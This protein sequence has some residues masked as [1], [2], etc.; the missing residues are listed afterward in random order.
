MNGKK[1]RVCIRLLAMVG[2]IVMLSSACASAAW[3]ESVDDAALKIPA[4]YG[5]AEW[6]PFG[7]DTVK[8]EAVPGAENLVKAE[9]LSTDG[10][11]RLYINGEKVT[12]LAYFD[13]QGVNSKETLTMMKEQENLVSVVLSD[14]AMTYPEN[15]RVEIVRTCLHEILYNNPDAYIIWRT[16]PMGTLEWHG[17]EESEQMI[18]DINGAVEKRRG[19]SLASD[20]YME[21]ITGVLVEIL[22]MIANDELLRERVIG[23]APLVYTTGEWF[24]IDFFEGAM[25]IS[26]PVLRKFR[27]W[28]TYRYKTDA[29]LQ[30]AW[31]DE[32]VTLTT[33]EIPEDIPGFIRRTETHPSF[34]LTDEEQQYVDFTLYWND[35]ISFRQRQMASVYKQATAGRGLGIFFYGY[36]NELCGAASGHFNMGAQLD[37]PY[38]DAFSGPVSY[39]DRNETGVGTSMSATA[40]IHAAGKMWFDESDYRTPIAGDTGGFPKIADLDAWI[41]V[42]RREMGK[43]LAEGIGTW[44][45]GSY[46]SPEIWQESAALSELYLKYDALAGKPDYDVAFV[47]DEQGMALCGRPYTQNFPLLRGNRQAAAVAGVTHGYYL[48]EDFI[49]GRI[50]ADLVIV[51][52]CYSLSTE[53]TEKLAKEAHRDGRTTLW[54]NGFGEMTAEQIHYLTGMEMDTVYGNWLTKA[55]FKDNEELGFSCDEVIDTQALVEPLYQ[56][57]NEDV[58]VLASFDDEDGSPALVAKDIG[59]STQMYYTDVKL[60][61]KMIRALAEMAGV[62]NGLEAGDVYYGNGNMSV[63]HTKMAGEK[64]LYL[65]EAADVYCYFTGK[66]FENVTEVTI[67]MEKGQ[68]EYFFIGDKQVFTA[69]EIGG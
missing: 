55:Y 19:P 26:E 50:D 48:L 24:T 52:S 42:T 2:V 16:T 46:H 69:A 20:G 62:K 61:G 40:A 63:L 37:C 59:K 58:T 14:S 56:A 67:T 10:R 9:I 53:E 12:P 57:V 30:A 43:V 28:L 35:L 23:F 17:L 13:Y 44:W 66:W 7:D 1:H 68:T 39:D 27:E 18:I 25:E 21:H 31:G 32:T 15:V 45:M 38:I 29:A 33:V 36:Y 64:T 65:D 3:K 34:M 51:L 60:S 8:V 11:P 6:H 49:E 22:E 41:E 4:A 54:M 5:S 47:I